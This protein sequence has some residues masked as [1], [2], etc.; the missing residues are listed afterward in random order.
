[1]IVYA[2]QIEHNGEYNLTKTPSL[3]DL[4]AFTA[5]ARHLNFSRAAFEL[6]ITRSAL[7]H[8]IRLLENQLGIRLLNRT[9]R[10]VSLT[11]SGLELL[12]RVS[13]VLNDLDSIFD[14]LKEKNG[15][16][17]GVLRINVSEVTAQILLKH[18]IPEF[19]RLY[20]LMRIDLTIDGRFV[21]IVEKGFDAG[22]R[23][24]EAVPLNMIAIPFGSPI[25]FIAVAS[26]S[27]LNEYKVLTNPD[28]LMT[29][30]CIRQRLPGGALYHWEFLLNGE[31]KNINVPGVLTLDNTNLMLKAAVEGMGIA[32]VPEAAAQE[33]L[34]SKL[35]KIVLDE[36]CPVSP[37][38]CLYFPDRRYISSGLRGF[39][40]ILKE[41]LPNQN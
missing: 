38:L 17:S 2:Q 26:P 8:T 36:W 37:G 40:N 21:D 28:D 31:K 6:G 23:L 25:R 7:S 3:S 39:I 1:M 14:C 32:Y 29:H 9:T 5:V 35:L 33:Y 11:E 19:T 15:C 4:Q 20:P 30:K 27:Y 12:T 24:A 22:V 34:D 16:P 13:P 18:V 41:K 10:S